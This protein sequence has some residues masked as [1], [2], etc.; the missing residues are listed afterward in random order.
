VSVPQGLTS[1]E[2]LRR[3]RDLGPNEP[4]PAPSR[5]SIVSVG[6]LFANPLVVILLVASAAS[7]ALGDI[8]NAAIIVVMVMLSVTLNFVQTYRSERAADRLREQVAPR[9]TV[10]RDGAWVDIP[11]SAVV[12]G[13]VV[14]LVAG[15]RVPADAVLIEA[16]DLHVYE[17]ALTG[18]SMPVE[19]SAAGA[20][21]A[22]TTP[23][24]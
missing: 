23:V 15:D 10:L 5:L 13:D 24:N 1:A 18:E 3:L 6:R 11:R 21:G 4:A 22:T 14:R 8:L 9:A 12:P 17:A 19:K 7:A 2:A 20:L 16:R